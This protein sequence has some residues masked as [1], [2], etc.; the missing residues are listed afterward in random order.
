M[1]HTV[2]Y[3][4]PHASVYVSNSLLHHVPNTLLN[5]TTT[6]C[7][8]QP[9]VSR[10]PC[11]GSA[12]PKVALGWRDLENICLSYLDKLLVRSLKLR[13]GP[14]KDHILRIM[15]ISHTHRDLSIRVY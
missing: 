13:V 4:E 8:P 3:S 5:Q 7:T 14:I 2:V 12:R 9:N 15:S 11:H 1:P 10:A 6:Y